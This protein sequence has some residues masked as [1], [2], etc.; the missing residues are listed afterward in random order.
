MIQI[1]SGFTEE[2]LHRLS[3][4]LSNLSSPWCTADSQGSMGKRVCNNPLLFTH[5]C[6]NAPIHRYKDGC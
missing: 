6:L 2:A 1:I 3:P 4:L 5:A